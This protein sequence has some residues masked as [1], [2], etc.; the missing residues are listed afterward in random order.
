M[1]AF[2]VNYSTVAFPLHLPIYLGGMAVLFEGYGHFIW[3]VW[4]CYLGVWPFH[5]GDMVVLFGRYGLIVWGV[6][7]FHLDCSFIWG[8]WPLY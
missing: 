3:G 4:L 1:I 2:F 8:V 5:L 7:P 6:W